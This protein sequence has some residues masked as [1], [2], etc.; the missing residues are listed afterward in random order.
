VTGAA[1]TGRTRAGRIDAALL[2]LAVVLALGTG[3]LIAVPALVPAVLSDRLDLAIT[4][5]ALLVAG[6]VAALEW[7]RGRVTGDGTALARAS[8]F[9]VLA[10][11]NGATLAVLL[12]GVEDAVGGSL[13]AP[14]QLPIVAGI[15]A[16]A[17]CAAL[18]VASGVPA[19][20]RLASRSHPAVVGLGPAVAVLGVLV[21]A[22]TNQAALPTLAAPSVLDSLTRAPTEIVPPGS[23]PALVLV[24]A[25]IGAGFLVAAVLAHR[26]YRVSG[27]TGQAVL[28]AGLMVAAFSQVHVALH[29]GSFASLTTTGDLL[30]LA[31]YGILLG[32]IVID[33]RD[34]L[35]ELR[36][37]NAEVR[38]LAEAEVAG[39]AFQ[40][41]ARLAR[42]IH[43]G[44][45]QDLWYAKLK[46]SR[47]AGLARFDGEE[48]QLSDEVTSAID[49]ALAEARHAVTA[50]REVAGSGPL[51]DVL[52][53]HI[54]DFAD[55]FALRAELEVRGA[56]PDLDPRS[57]AEVLRIVQE[58]LTNVRRHA[59]ATVV[60]VL[61]EAGEELRVAVTDNGRGFRSDPPPA[62]FGLDSMRQ[63]AELM[64]GRLTVASQPANGTR[65]TLHLPLKGGDGE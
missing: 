53:R 36:G 64:G 48:Q 5:S 60:R 28:A 52:R 31:F 35:R 16:R 6:A 21:L 2:A 32:G 17:T 38:R 11:L 26:A 19:V 24:Q 10:V 39:A 8:A 4:T 44:L 46:Q 50:M 61:V 54:D 14:G 42:E 43:D 34:D 30:R 29:P 41:R 55:R 23:A 18:L 56:V 59:D 9:V 3:I 65:V 12:A 33:R 37:A 57:A 40:E 1:V 20:S 45:A 7:A 58:S 25:A 49:A 13:A 47:L 15:V 51:L 22:A 63:R 27:R 62:G